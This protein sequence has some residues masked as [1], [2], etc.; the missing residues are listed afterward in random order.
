MV[1]L[2]GFGQFG[3]TALVGF[4]STLTD[5]KLSIFSANEQTLSQ[6]KRAAF[7]SALFAVKL[8]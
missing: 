7:A 2:M 6:D 1:A 4:F 8:G 5:Y 3:L